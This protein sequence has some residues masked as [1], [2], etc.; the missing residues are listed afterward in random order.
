MQH[1]SLSKLFIIGNVNIDLILG[2]LEQ[3]PRKGTE[4]V[5]P[6]C[7]WRPGGSA[8][9]TALALQALSA[10]VQLIANRGNDIFG[11]WLATQFCHSNQWPVSR[12]PTSVTVGITHSDHERTFFTGQG[13]VEQLSSHDVLAQ[14]PLTGEH[15]IV[16][17]SGAFLTTALLNDYESL[18][19]TL[20]LRGYRVALDCG[21]PPQGW[22]PLRSTIY[23]W[24]TYIDFLLLNDL[25]IEHLAEQT[26][27]SL[28]SQ[29]LAA[30]MP[31]S[32]CIVI[33]QGKSGASC[34]YQQHVWHVEAPTV[35]VV[36]TI[37]AGDIFNA[38]FLY[39]QIAQQPINQSL[40]WAIT[41]ASQTIATSPRR[42][43]TAHEFQNAIA[44]SGAIHHG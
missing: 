20:K 3:W 5:L 26:D 31:P 37:G 25:E 38:G 43:M 27:V 12:T 42:F 24:L 16:L 14:L 39:A 44:R 29:F 9:N 10:P 7:A 35:D 15:Q 21:W 41:L 28:A 30:H 6:Q 8:G 36:D 32:A 19:Q 4:V 1:A 11:E 23:Q 22:D 17:L 2:S 34:W 33:K 13:N 40:D 18:L